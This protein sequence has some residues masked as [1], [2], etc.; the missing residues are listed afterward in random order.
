MIVLVIRR[1]PQQ[2]MQPFILPL[3]RVGAADVL[4]HGDN[5]RLQR[6]VFRLEGLKFENVIIIPLHL[7]H[8]GAGSGTERRQDRLDRL[9]A[10]AA[11]LHG[12]GHGHK[13][14]QQDRN[15]DKPFGL[16]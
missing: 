13:S 6:L 15:D 12:R 10:P 4:F 8:Q 2:L 16:G 5:L 3:E 14:G 7:A 9:L 1:E 11:G